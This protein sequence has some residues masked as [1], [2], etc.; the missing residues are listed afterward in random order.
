[1]VDTNIKTPSGVISGWDSIVLSDESVLVEGQISAEQ[2]YAYI[3]GIVSVV[4]PRRLRGIEKTILNHIQNDNNPHNDT[5]AMLGDDFVAQILERVTPGTT[6]RQ[7][8]ALSYI[9]NMELPDDIT[10][11]TLSRA[12]PM[13]VLDRQGYMTTAAENETGVDWSTGTAIVPLFPQVT[14]AIPVTDTTLTTNITTVGL[15]TAAAASTAYL[16][17]P[18]KDTK[19]LVMYETADN[20]AHEFTV[21]SPVTKGE[22]DTISFFLYPHNGTGILVL[23]IRMNSGAADNTKFATINLSNQSTTVTTD[24]SYAVHLSVLPNGWWRCGLQ[25]VPTEDGVAYLDVQHT[26]DGVPGSTYTGT[27][28]NPLFSIFKINS[29]N[30]PGFAPILDDSVTPL[31]PS[32]LTI[33]ISG[34]PAVIGKGMYA[35]DFNKQFSLLTTGTGESLFSSGVG[36]TASYEGNTLVTKNT[37]GTQPLTTNMTLTENDATWAISLD[38]SQYMVKATGFT[39]VKYGGTFTQAEDLSLFTFGP[40]YGGLSQ[41]SYYAVSDD[42]RAL[43]YL[44]GE[45]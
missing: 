30:T 28:G 6:P 27:S 35:I 43:E 2:L 38:A 22:E 37:M 16:K 26:T 17:S 8:P 3:K 7:Y 15:T 31:A 4:D 14:Q 9:A 42:N 18:N 11:V 29:T 25:F 33:P 20:G 34:S 39:K 21:A 40:F 44:V 24:G 36:I 5:I 41:F 13:T 19:Y 1:M 45:N 12:S 23:Q 10:V 32:V